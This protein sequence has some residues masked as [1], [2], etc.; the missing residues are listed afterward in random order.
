MS[1]HLHVPPRFA[2]AI[3]VPRTAVLLLIALLTQGLT[4]LQD[5]LHAQQQHQVTGT[6]TDQTT[7]A[8]L[9]NV[10]VQIRD[11][12]A[13][14]LTN[15]EGRYSITAPSPSAVLV[16]S[17]LG[18]TSTDVPLDGRSVVDVAMESGAIALEGLTVMGY[19][20]V[21]TDRMT[22][23]VDVVDVEEIQATTSNSAIKALQGRVPGLTITANG[24]PS[25]EG[26]TVRIR[27]IS[28]LGNNDPLYVIDGIPTKSQAAHRIRPEDIESIQVLK[29]AASASIYGARASNGVIVITTKSPERQPM[30][31]N[32][33]TSLTTSSYVDRLAVLNTEERGRALWQAAI[34]D[35]V[36]PANLPIYDY[37]WTRTSDG[38][39]V[40]NRVIIPEYVNDPSAGIRS[41][42]TNWYDEISRQ[43]LLQE[44]SLSAATS[45]DR[46]GAMLSLS[47]FDDAGIVKGTDFERITARVNSSYNFFD[48][49]LTVGENLGL[50]RGQGS[51][52][53]SGLGGNPLALGLIA[54]PIL[55]VYTEDGGWAGPWGAGFDDRDNPVMVIALNEWDRNTVAQAFGNV[56]ADLQ[57]TPN[58]LATARFGVDWQNGSNRDIQ[59]RYQAGFLRRDVNSMAQFNYT[60]FDWTFSSTLNYNLTHSRHRATILGGVEALRS[61]FT[62]ARTFREDFALETESFFV[63]NA[64]TGR[65]VVEGNRGGYSLASLFG[66]IDYDYDNRYLASV[67]IRHDGSSRFGSNNRF[68]TF[69]AVAAAWRISNEAFFPEDGLFSDLKLR[70]SWG[71]T[72]NQEIDNNASFALYIPNYGD[73]HTWGPGNGTAYDLGGFDSG[74]LPSGFFRTQTGNPD[75]RWESTTEVNFGVDYRLLDDRLSGS[76]DFFQRDTEDILISPAFIGVVGDGGARWANGASMET[77]GAEFSLGY[78]DNFG[79]VSFGITGNVGSYRDKITSLPEDVVKSYPGNVEQTILGRSINSIFGYV[80]DGIFQ[81][82]EEVAAHANQPGKGVGRLRYA[83]LNDDGII[84]ALDQRFLGTTSPDF[85][86]GLSSNLGY[87]SF[88]LSFFL[89]GVQGVDVYNG[90]KTQTDFTS[91]FTGANFGTRVLDAWT[92]ENPNSRIP[93]LTLANSNNENRSSTYFVE[94]GSYLKL[95]EVVLGY[96]LPAAALPGVLSRMEGA[97]LYL[98]GANLFTLKKTSG[99][100]ATTLPDPEV[101]FGGYPLPRTFTFGV[102]LSF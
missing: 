101:P 31:I 87:R 3:R 85:T 32:Y 14:T 22:A 41:A 11:T 37:D 79:E 72:G 76:A 56:F 47:L 29:D 75:L 27:G 20:T 90:I 44:H 39:A 4:A 88:D 92:P 21:E 70:A 95:R 36:D 45:G 8:P 102:D 74:T 49:R 50:S 5:C 60:D 25:Q 81:S 38:R 83:D 94:D 54:Q 40:L 19:Q 23:A 15:A 57:V 69:P 100:N 98:R 86:Y 33:S 65:Q 16:F 13:G 55:P 1:H 26:A 68:G 34:N 30:T 43:G 78:N 67:T 9:P 62:N 71:V 63:E 61:T 48:G 59:R 97:R 84:D 17:R 89:Q 10:S 53:P 99:E 2:G 64:G 42:D 24:N 58:L 6:V 73:D 66:K 51:P 52:L 93:A 7:G 82:E 18:Y 80:V 12:P 91:I 35:G 28:T 77:Q 46:G 96:T